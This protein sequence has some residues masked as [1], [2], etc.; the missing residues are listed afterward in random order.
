MSIARA[1][2]KDGR[3]VEFYTDMIGDGAMKEVYFTKDRKSVVCFYKDASAGSDPVR[4]KR[5]EMILG[6]YNPTLAQ[7]QGGAA[8]SDVEAAYFR[9]LYCW[10]TGIVT[11]PRFGLVTPAYPSHFFFESGPDFIKG[12]EKNGMRFIGHKNRA[13]LERFAPNEVGEWRNYL[14]LCIRMARAV[15]RMHNAGLAHSDLSPNNVLVDPSRGVSIVIDIDSLVV[16]GLF[17]PDVLG[18]KGYI[19]PEVLS[20]IHLPIKDPQRKHP[21]ARTDQ[22]ALAV[23]IYQYLLRRHPLDGKRVP[24]AKTAEEQ[25]LLAHGSQALYCEH[26]TDTSNRP[27]EKSYVPCAALGPFLSD[28]FQRAFVKGL[29][30]PNDRPSALEWLRGLIK[31]VDLLVPCSN[32]T[33]SHKWY[34]LHNPADLRCS[35]CGA[36]PVNRV[37]LLKL[38]AERRQGQWLPDGQVAVHDGLSLFKWHVFDNVFPGPEADRTRQAYC[39]FHQGRWLLVN[40]SLASLTT[41]NGNRVPAS[42]AVELMD[43]AQIRLSQEA[44]GRIV[45]VQLIG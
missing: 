23:L 5:L 31:T 41:P 7:S 39:T 6:K 35:F 18:T 38:R 4:I 34:V 8:A 17:P 45:E 12:K 19:A 10:P 9:D 37:P 30:A 15:A 14:A 22:H 28:L 36:K 1:T 21:S 11:H 25:E 40:E 2:L 43:G 13:L 29:H 3:T 24:P 27:E 33:C 42:Q 32:R 16:E 20:T 44:H 26:P